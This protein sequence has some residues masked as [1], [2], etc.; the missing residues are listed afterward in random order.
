VELGVGVDVEVRGD[1]APSDR[2]DHVGVLRGDHEDPGDDFMALAAG[3]LDLG[4]RLAHVFCAQPVEDDPVRLL[5][6]QVEHAGPQGGQV[7][8]GL[9][10]GDAGQAETVD[11]E[12]FVG[13]RDLL[14]GQGEAEEPQRVAHS[15]VLVLERQAVPVGHD[16][17]G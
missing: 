1:H 12:P 15:P 4:H 14:A 10:L 8:V 5:A 9:L 2:A 6:G 17:F 7:E 11:R 3:A 16:H 13:G